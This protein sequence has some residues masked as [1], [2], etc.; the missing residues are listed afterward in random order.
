MRKSIR[1]TLDSTHGLYLFELGKLLWGF[2]EL[3]RAIHVDISLKIAMKLVL[4]LH[5]GAEKG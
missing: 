5:A 4:V 2:M 3:I 1:V